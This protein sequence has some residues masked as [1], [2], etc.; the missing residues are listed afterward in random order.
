MTAIG[1]FDQFILNFVDS[2]WQKV[3]MVIAKALATMS[4]GS[5]KS[6]EDARF[7]A[8]RVNELIWT[9]HPEANGDTGN[10]RFNEVRRASGAMD[11]A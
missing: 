7:V 11:A 1:E 3:A 10:W 5:P 9:G 2:N 8:N 6:E 4:W